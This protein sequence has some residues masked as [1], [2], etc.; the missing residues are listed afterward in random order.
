MT[1][2]PARQ[3]PTSHLQVRL[4]VSLQTI[5]DTWTE[6]DREE[7]WRNS[8][9]TYVLMRPNI[10][11]SVLAS[12][13]DSILYKY[14]G[15]E[16]STRLFLQ[17]LTD[18]HLTSDL[19]A[20]N[21]VTTDTRR[22]FIYVLAALLVVIIACLNFVNLATVQTFLRSKE[23]GLRSCL[24]ASL[25][26]L[27]IQLLGE[28]ALTVGCAALLAIVWVELAFPFLRQAL[29]PLFNLPIFE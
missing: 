28:T 13:I 29:E 17:S 14:R 8:F 7:W 15:E 6:A 16:N 19:V 3:Y 12:R 10:D 9:S 1:G 25:T 20:D 4:L 5:S 18:I 27:R 24:G 11:R 21:S 2:V 23:V 22:L 26:Q